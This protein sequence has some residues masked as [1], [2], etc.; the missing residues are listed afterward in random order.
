ME[1]QHSMTIN[2]NPLSFSLGETILDVARRN[3]IDIPTL[4][5]LKGASP[6][7]VCRVCVVEVAGARNLL[8]ACA[9]PADDNMTVK[10]ESAKGRGGS[11]V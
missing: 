3:S 6:T 10:T 5:H 8:P 4:C 11:Q 1:S 2:G 7:G 9:T